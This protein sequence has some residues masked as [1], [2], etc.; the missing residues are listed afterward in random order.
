MNGSKFTV[1]E[2]EDDSR[3]VQ[4]HHTD[5]AQTDP[6]PSP[7][8]PRFAEHEPEPEATNEPSPKDA[9]VLRIAS[10]LE[11]VMS[12]QVHEPATELTMGENGEGS[13]AHRTI[14]EGELILDLG[15]LD[16]IDF[17]SEVITDTSHV[18]PPSLPL[19]SPIVPAAPPRLPAP[20]SSPSAHQLHPAPP[21]SVIVLPSP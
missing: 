14:V 1:G 8:S 7:P 3:L 20:L 2:A 10:D 13:S 19:L 21:W 6:E 4:P 12:D 16:L 17:F 15:Q 18:F 5:V 11:P 9:T